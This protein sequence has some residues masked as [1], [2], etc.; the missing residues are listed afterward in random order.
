MAT[1]EKPIPRKFFKSKFEEWQ[2]S[3]YEIIDFTKSDVDLSE[4]PEYYEEKYMSTDRKI[5]KNYLLNHLIYYNLVSYIK[6]VNHYIFKT[7]GFKKIEYFL[8]DSI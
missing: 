8:Q 5:E 4:L 1:L 6:E 3:G 7:I 2:T